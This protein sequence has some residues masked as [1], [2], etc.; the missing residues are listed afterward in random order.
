M[1]LIYYI[2]L[3]GSKIPK[4]QNVHHFHL[5]T[6][7]FQ[8]Y[9]SDIGRWLNFWKVPKLF[10]HNSSILQSIPLFLSGIF[11]PKPFQPH[12]PL[13]KYF[14]QLPSFFVPS[15]GFCLEHHLQSEDQIRVRIV[16]LK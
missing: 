11:S 7:T 13:Q 5:M 12:I 15:V 8:I 4:S 9:Q 1:H 2:T 10:H 6:E 14:L 3:K 16:S